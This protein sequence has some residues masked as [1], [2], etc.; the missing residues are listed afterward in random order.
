MRFKELL[1]LVGNEPTFESS[2]L[3]AGDV[4]PGYIR[5]QLTRWKKAG[6]IYQLRRGL[7]AIAPPFQKTNPHPFLIANHIVKASY[8]SAQSALRFY[9]LIPDIVMQTT[10]ITGKRPGTWETPLGIYHYQHIKPDLLSGYQ[11]AQ[12]G[13]GQQAF[14]AKPEKALLDLIYLQPQGDSPGYL[15]E[16]R[17]QNVD[18]LDVDE[19]HRQVE[20]FDTPK[21][22]RALNEIVLLSR[23]E[24]EYEIL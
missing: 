17:L 9:G 5:L 16:L 12:L 7:Y 15:R 14:V 4:S 11:M 1:T 21:M 13:N 24:E 19:L 8:V 18:Q 6:R 23:I 3:L 22:Y 20:I 2:L 10:S